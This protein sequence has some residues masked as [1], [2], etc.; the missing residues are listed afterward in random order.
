MSWH[1]APPR[2]CEGFVGNRIEL[3]CVCSRDLEPGGINQQTQLGGTILNA[4]GWMGWTWEFFWTKRR[5]LHAS[6]VP[7]LGNQY[8]NVWNIEGALVNF[9]GRR[10]FFH[11]TLAVLAARF[12]PKTLDA[13]TG[14]YDYENAVTG[15]KL[16]FQRSGSWCVGSDCSSAVGGAN[17]IGV[18]MTTH[19]ACW[20]P[21]LYCWPFLGFWEGTFL[22]PPVFCL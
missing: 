18:L 2:N 3:Q 20:N 10:P 4:E 1:M 11:F 14:R 22:K 19:E 15:D 8:E 21:W 7:S 17:P 6:Q 12:C 16:V 13:H 5:D 9:L